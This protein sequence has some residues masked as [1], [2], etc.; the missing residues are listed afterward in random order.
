MVNHEGGGGNATYE[1]HD[2]TGTVSE[3]PTSDRARS[4]SNSLYRAIEWWVTKSEIV[5]QLKF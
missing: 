1:L 2:A 3:L 4:Y 5:G